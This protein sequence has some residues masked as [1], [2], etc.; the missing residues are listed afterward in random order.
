MSKPGIC[1][2]CGKEMMD[3]AD[4]GYGDIFSCCNDPDCPMFHDHISAL[5]YKDDISEQALRIL[6]KNYED[7]KKY[8]EQN[9]PTYDDNLK[10]I[11]KEISMKKY[12]EYLISNGWEL[13]G[14]V[15]HK[16]GA[17]FNKSGVEEVES[18]DELKMWEG[19]LLNT[20]IYNLDE[21]EIDNG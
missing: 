17:E 12:H 14:E 2:C 21:K 7:A 20:D 19:V 1:P 4:N 9:I 6:Q 3:W 18:L 15:Y 8:R 10:R 11:A 16:N 5:W 13:I